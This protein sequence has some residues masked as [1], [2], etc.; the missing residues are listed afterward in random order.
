MTESE[1]EGGEAAS[2]AP[3]LPPEQDLSPPEIVRELD[4]FI[5][6]QDQ[7]KR[8]VAVAL[9]NRWRRLR[10]E[11]PMRDEITP[12]N[13]ILIGPTG[14]GKTEISR[15]LAKLVKAPFVKVEASKFTE[16][17]YVGRDVDSIVRD[18]AEA[19]YT[20]VKAEER[21]KVRVRA[22]EF[23][24]ERLLDLLLPGSKPVD[25]AAAMPAGRADAGRG[26][27]ILQD[28]AGVG[29]VESSASARSQTREK[30]R[31]LF[32]EGA[33]DARP[34]EVETVKQ[35]TAHLQV[36]GPPGMNELEGQLKEMFANVMP[37]QRERRT[38]S[39]H[40]AW[41]VLVQEAQESLLDQEKLAQLAV[42]RAEESGI[43]FID[44]IDK[45]CGSVAGKGPDVS[46]EGVQRD[47][48]PI[49]EGSVVN[50]RYGAVNT[51]HVLFIASG[52][53]HSAKP[54]DLMPEFQGRFPIRVELR[55]LSPEDFVRIL[56][57]PENSLTKQYQALLRTEGVELRFAEEAIRK[58]AELTA[59]VNTR[60]ENI[61]ARR[62]ATL[63]EKVLDTLLFSAHGRG[64]E[65]VWIDEAYVS[66]A[67]A[68]IVKDTDLSRFIL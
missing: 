63:L 15:R 12:K 5:I 21:E 67:L 39:V 14:V 53:F 26:T 28:E 44:E 20:L 55:S 1:R 68:D 59:E 22:E 57:E 27:V 42:R 16:V 58:L 47:L 10:V 49:V 54:S 33:L 2:H 40:E 29:H 41:K 31:R 61:G 6:G 51:T 24:E 17:G 37:K 3:A 30:L 52:A 62:L 19:S 38:M 18:L 60:T 11:G 36:L 50:T 7:A 65:E 45:I 48:L 43:V 32:R 4:R 46:R 25:A 8:A 56:T 34:V 9:R 66:R 13:I 35:T 23:A 64:G